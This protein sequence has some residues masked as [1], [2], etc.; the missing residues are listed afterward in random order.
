MGEDS[1]ARELARGRDRLHGKRVVVWEFA[2]RELASGTWNLVS[3]KSR[4]QDETRVLVLRPGER[5][6][7]KA[8]VESIGTL[9]R[10]GTTPYR[11]DDTKVSELS[12]SSDPQRD[13]YA[14]EHGIRA[15]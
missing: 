2:I 6:T 10:P 1:L 15:V 11:G 8:T 12:G 9:P 5:L 3:L 13:I 14:A 7:A 4:A